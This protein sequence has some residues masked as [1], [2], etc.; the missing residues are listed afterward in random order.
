MIATV[1]TLLFV[2]VVFS[3]LHREEV[4]SLETKQG[5]PS[6]LKPTPEDRSGN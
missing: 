2:P 3:Y 1:A 4:N 6:A 5:K